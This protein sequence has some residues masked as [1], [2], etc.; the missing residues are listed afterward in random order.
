MHG[1]L[2]AQITV[3]QVVSGEWMPDL[4]LLPQ[5]PQI[6][7]CY[8]RQLQN[9]ENRQ[10][11]NSHLILTL[12]RHVHATGQHLAS[13][14]APPLQ[15]LLCAVHLIVPRW[16]CVLMCTSTQYNL[17][18]D[19][20]LIKLIY[21]STL[22]PQSKQKLKQKPKNKHKKTMWLRMRIVPQRATYPCFAHCRECVPSLVCEIALGAKQSQSQLAHC[23]ARW[24]LP[25]G[26]EPRLKPAPTSSLIHYTRTDTHTH[27]C[28]HIHST[29]S[30]LV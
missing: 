14:L 23:C 27:I 28:T 30:L 16:A 22:L 9:S 26:A 4:L 24:Q 21:C 18:I 11:K 3:K 10:N 17:W 12:A 7:R 15:S 6:R 5:Q 1:C 19:F 2:M 20:Q 8:L 13:A 29:Q 25:L